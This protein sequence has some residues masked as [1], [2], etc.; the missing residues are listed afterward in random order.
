MRKSFSDNDVIKS[1]CL[2]GCIS[3]AKVASRGA[4]KLGREDFFA[5]SGASGP[6]SDSGHCAYRD[7]LSAR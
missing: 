7:M 2:D 1:A 6:A 4:S 5:G 3:F